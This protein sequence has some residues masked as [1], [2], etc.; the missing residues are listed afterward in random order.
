MNEEKQF[1]GYIP[2]TITITKCLIEDSVNVIE[3][4]IQNT[5]ALLIEH[6][7]NLGRTT[8]KDRAWAAVLENDIHYMKEIASQLRTVLWAK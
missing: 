1:Q 2:E 8:L 4:G 6:D 3:S 7:S 5:H